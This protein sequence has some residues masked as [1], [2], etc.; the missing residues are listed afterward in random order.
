MKSE[1]CNGPP[2]VNVR[3]RFE[4]NR[5]AMEAQA[6]AYQKVLPVGCRSEARTMAN[7]VAKDPGNSKLASQEGVAA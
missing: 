4:G 3:R 7:Q 5:L 6:G 2:P 1:A